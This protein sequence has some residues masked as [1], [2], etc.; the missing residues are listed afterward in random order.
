MS[1][2]QSLNYFEK[3]LSKL[4]DND[5]N[6]VN[7]VMKNVIDEKYPKDI[8]YTQEN[9]ESLKALL[10]IKILSNIYLL[11]SGYTEARKILLA[12]YDIQP[13]TFHKYILNDFYTDARNNLRKEKG[14]LKYHDVEINTEFTHCFDYSD[15]GYDSE[16]IGLTNKFFDFAAAHK[17]S[18]LPDFN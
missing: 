7:S 11:S 9:P 2:K 16:C 12:K 8:K 17:I 15:Y 14:F 10:A 3:V 18:P 5:T 13:E 6:S 4:C 1:Y